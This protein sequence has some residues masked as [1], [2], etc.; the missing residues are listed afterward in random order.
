[1]QMNLNISNLNAPNLNMNLNNSFLRNSE[2]SNKF[3]RFALS[4][5]EIQ[6]GALLSTASVPLIAATGTVSCLSA[7][8]L[9]VLDGPSQSLSSAI[10]NDS[11]K[12]PV[13]FPSTVSSQLG[14]CVGISAGYGTLLGL[15]AGLNGS[16]LGLYMI[17]DG[18]NAMTCGVYQ[19]YSGRG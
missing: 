8:V 13:L 18:M 17:E 9:Q 12:N 1:M 3:I 7:S 11:G 19:E 5:I 10:G 14:A 2:G 4:P 6:V 16:K 15:E